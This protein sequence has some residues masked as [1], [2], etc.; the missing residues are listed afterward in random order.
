MRDAAGG[1]GVE[2][3][4]HGWLHHCSLSLELA[5]RL[6]FSEKKTRERKKNKEFVREGS[7]F[8]VRVLVGE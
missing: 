8:M 7:Q 2:R 6:S 3:S 1:G 4:E 5:S